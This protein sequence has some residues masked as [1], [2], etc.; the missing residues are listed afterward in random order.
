MRGR[1]VSKRQYLIYAFV[2]VILMVGLWMGVR[3]L[4]SSDSPVA[5]GV[6]ESRTDLQVGALSERLLTDHFTLS[7]ERQQ[8]IW[9]IEHL[10]F[11]LIQDVVPVFKG[12]IQEDR[13]EP[14]LRLL[15]PGFQGRVFEGE[16]TVDRHGPV[17]VQRWEDEQHPSKELDRK[18]FV[19]ELLSYARA[20]SKVEDVKVHVTT[21]SPVEEGNFEGPWRAV[22]DMHV[23]GLLNEGGRAERMLQCS[24]RFRHL[25]DTVASTPGWI[26]RI[27]VTRSWH[28]SSP[29]VLM[30]EITDTTGID[31]KALTDNWKRGPPRPAVTGGAT[32]LD[33]DRDGRTDLLINDLSRVYLYRG[34]GRGKFEDVTVAAGLPIASGHRI[35]MHAADLDNDGFEDLLL[36]RDWRAK[37]IY[38][39]QGDGTFR[40]LPASE[41]NLQK[42][43]FAI[44]GIADYDGDGRLDLYLAKAGGLSDDDGPGARWVGDRTSAEGVLLQNLGGWKF[45]DVTR[46]AGLTG[47]FVDT[48]AAVWLDLEPDG[49]PDL[50]LANHMG[51]NVL[52]EN[53]GDGTF[54]K[55]LIRQGFGGFS[56][57]ATA[58]DLDGDGDPDLY[59]A[60]MYSAAGT[61]VMEHL[62]PEDY[63]EGAI[64]LIQ[65]FVTGNELYLNGGAEGLAPQGV[66]AGVSNSGWSYGPALVDLDGDGSL[67]I[68]AP[69]GFQSVT[70]G[71]PDG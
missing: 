34:L 33:I 71:N 56:M 21:L 24:L 51:P 58:G 29:R 60:N 28:A 25:S 57:G 50:F 15:A 38:E 4:D 10:A 41:H 9:E 3:R 5:G 45:A 12:A 64:D 18:A 7:E 62:R 36:M 22:W 8:Y 26:E 39:N 37:D 59:V 69:A 63:P 54:V 6:E 46:E 40:K 27:A 1:A 61:R 17:T 20:F 14:L 70:R 52:W 67:D 43:L 48:F 53:R 42:Y 31:V 11:V 19:E 65:G 47:E 49:D 16:G 68:Y 44:F 30:E 23:T 13:A 55:R 2:G 35:A 66:S 32:L